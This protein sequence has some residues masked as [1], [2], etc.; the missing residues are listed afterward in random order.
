LQV[1]DNGV[2]QYFFG[3]NINFSF[4]KN[5]ALQRTKTT[6]FLQNLVLNNQT[7]INGINEIYFVNTNSYPDG[8]LNITT[9]VCFDTLS[10]ANLAYSLRVTSND[11]S[12]ILKK[13]TRN[14]CNEFIINGT[15]NMDVYNTYNMQSFDNALFNNTLFFSSHT[16]NSIKISD[17]S[18]INDF[19]Y[20]FASNN[21]LR[22]FYDDLLTRLTNASNFPLTID[23]LDI[24]IDMNQ[25]TN[26][27]FATAKNIP[28]TITC[29]NPDIPFVNNAT[30][31]VKAKANIAFG[32]LSS[33][34][35]INLGN[36]IFFAYDKKN[37]TDEE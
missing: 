23:D 1:Y 13:N 27:N 7:I 25:I 34:N 8:S 26:L 11:S 10:K 15:I 21:Y 24:S 2:Q 36:D 31:F 28:L 5:D 33:L 3:Q 19:N 18:Q 37:I 17:L 4:I 30:I 35:D 14:Y 16:P 32:D 22:I 29:I 9:D 20:K 12:Q 6:N